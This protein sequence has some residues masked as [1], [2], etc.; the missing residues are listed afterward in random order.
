MNNPTIMFTTVVIN[1]EVKTPADVARAQSDIAAL[2]NVKPEAITILGVRPFD[3]AS[4][5]QELLVSCDFPAKPAK[6][7][8]H[9]LIEA[10]A[11]LLSRKSL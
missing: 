8:A 5:T 1:G 10:I 9:P 4:G 7:V 6:W 2:S 11:L 3:V